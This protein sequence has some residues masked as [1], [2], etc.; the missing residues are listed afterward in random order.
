MK[1]ILRKCVWHHILNLL[2]KKRN[3]MTNNTWIVITTI[4]IYTLENECSPDIS[5][6]DPHRTYARSKLENLWQIW[7]LTKR[8]PNF[9]TIAVYPS[10]I[11]NGFVGKKIGL[12]AWLRSTQI[13]TEE[14]GA[15]SSVI[16]ATQ[17]NIPTLNSIFGIKFYKKNDL[18]KIVATEAKL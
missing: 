1:K 14:K 16:G 7:E 3:L 8:Y 2:L 4:D 12:I 5:F 11:A 15:H 9:N 10:V 17:Q 13:I 6:T 18:L